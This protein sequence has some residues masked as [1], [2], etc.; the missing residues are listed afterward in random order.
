MD[1]RFIDAQR[2]VIRVVD[3]HVHLDLADRL[4]VGGVQPWKGKVV[5]LAVLSS[6]VQGYTACACRRS[7]SMVCSQV[8]L[9]KNA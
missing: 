1:V 2:P 7:E 6:S 5:G 8:R 3:H 4:A 9:Y